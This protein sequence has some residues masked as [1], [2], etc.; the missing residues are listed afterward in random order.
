PGRIIDKGTIVVRDGVIEAVGPDVKPPVDARVIDLNGKS[1]YAGLIDAYGEIAVTADLTKHSSAHWN[2]QITPQLDIAE[3]YAADEALNGQLR[4][5]GITARLVA[6]GSRII[7]G[8]SIMVSTGEGN[9]ARAILRR[10]V[11]QHFRLTVPFGQGRDNYPGSPMGAVALARQ[12]LL[13]TDWYAKAWAAWRT[14]NKLP[15]PERN[16]ALDALAG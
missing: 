9:N 6:P 3:H 10:G 14:N 4:S 11:A 16:D 2:P 15:R 7:K 13:D 1:A 5:Q 8:Q 12:T